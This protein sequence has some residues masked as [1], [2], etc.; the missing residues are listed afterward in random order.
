[1]GININAEY[2]TTL[3]FVDDVELLSER[4]TELQKMIINLEKAGEEAGMKINFE[5]TKI[6]TNATE[7]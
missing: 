6:L 2:S 1:M 5:R 7:E 4:K 3:R